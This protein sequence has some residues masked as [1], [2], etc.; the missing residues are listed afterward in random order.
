AD[1]MRFAVL[2][3]LLLC[4]AHRSYGLQCYECTGFDATY[5]L[6][7]ATNNP[8]CAAGQFSPQGMT[9]KTDE[10]IAYGESYC[11]KTTVPGPTIGTLITKRYMIGYIIYPTTALTGQPTSYRSAN[12]T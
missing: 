10:N 9:I 4:I 2:P 7:W 5:G 12:V 6:N 11:V 3:W 1:K 8:G